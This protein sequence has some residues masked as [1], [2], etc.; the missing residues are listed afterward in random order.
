MRPA[1]RI[2]LP[3][4]RPELMTRRAIGI[5]L[6]VA[7]HLIAILL[8]FLM[9]PPIFV[10]KAEPEYKSF[11]LL[12]LRE[13][14]TEKKAAARK[15][16]PKPIEAVTAP[17]LPQPPPLPAAAPLRMMLVSSDVF[18]ASDIGKITSHVE[19]AGGTAGTGTADSSGNGEGPGGARLYNAEW[20]REPTQAEL[21]Y[22]LPKGTPRSGW[23]EIICRTIAYYRV[24]DC[25]ELNEGPMGSGM[26]RAIRQA[27][28]QFRVRPP[29]TDGK[30]MIG[31]WV[32][33]HYSLTVNGE[34]GG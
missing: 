6:A 19:G 25:R 15:A 16:T 23:G 33:I 4:V 29:R 21:A 30:P 32:R 13:A 22:Y 9:S 3:A 24:E 10:K 27:A 14:R 28:W 20:Y 31:A 8:A 2:I 7:V 26:A 12:A 34:K 5:S 17:K 18:A 11:P 1:F